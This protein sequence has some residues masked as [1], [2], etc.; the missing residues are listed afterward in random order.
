MGGPP[1]SL[2]LFSIKAS[3][4]S[5]SLWLHMWWCHVSAATQQYSD[6]F[7]SQ[8]DTP[9]CV[10]TGLQAAAGDYAGRCMDAG[11]DVRDARIS[12]RDGRIIPCRQWC[13]HQHHRVPL[14][15]CSQPSTTTVTYIY[16]SKA[17]ENLCLHVQYSQCCFQ[18][19]WRYL[20]INSLPNTVHNIFSCHLQ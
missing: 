2:P 7:F 16:T 13:S 17:S 4:H 18:G 15:L 19:C 10:Q 8:G 20:L 3:N 11:C 6:L 1:P 9:W 12:T 5:S 14:T